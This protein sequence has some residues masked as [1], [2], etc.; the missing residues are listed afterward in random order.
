[1][2]AVSYKPG[3][4]SQMA[5]NASDS[6]IAGFGAQGPARAGQMIPAPRPR[7]AG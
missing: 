3:L 5:Q 2:G 7:P 4:Y 1:M 6:G